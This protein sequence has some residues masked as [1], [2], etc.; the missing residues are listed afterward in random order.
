MPPTPSP[1]RAARTTKPTPVPEVPSD[2]T[3]EAKV[4][5]EYLVSE[6]EL[7]TE[8]AGFH[9]SPEMG[10]RVLNEFPE[11]SPQPKF[12]ERRIKDIPKDPWDHDYIYQFPAQHSESAFDLFSLGPDGIQSGDDI[13]NW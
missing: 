10:L 2:P 5:I 6:V 3:S 9:P 12:W 7:F 1:Q 4:K 11:G 8:R 13:G